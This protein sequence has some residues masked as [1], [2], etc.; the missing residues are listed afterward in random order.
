MKRRWLV[1]AVLCLLVLLG[2]CGL[3]CGTGAE[4]ALG[5][6]RYARDASWTEEP[7][8]TAGGICTE[9]TAFRIDPREDAY[10][11]LF[12]YEKAGAPSEYES[13]SAYYEKKYRDPGAY[14]DLQR[15][16]GEQVAGGEALHVAFTAQAEGEAAY[17]VEQYVFDSRDGLYVVSL[18]CCGGRDKARAALES[19]IGSVRFAEG[20]RQKL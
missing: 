3:R 1:P 18:S 13:T 11:A 9:S 20:T 10:L 8:E 2:G 17:Y 6:I 14:R 5:E 15:L 19:L 16:E 4:A 12:Y 7:V